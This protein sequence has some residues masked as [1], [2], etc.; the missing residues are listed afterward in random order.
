MPRDSAAMIEECRV[1]A[2]GVAMPEPRP[3]PSGAV[4]VSPLVLADLAT[5]TGIS[6]HRVVF[7]DSPAALKPTALL[8]RDCEALVPPDRRENGPSRCLNPAS[9]R[10]VASARAW[11]TNPRARR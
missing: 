1:Q 5:N 3:T 2:A 7:A 10:R 11:H 6:G 4:T 9:A 8:I